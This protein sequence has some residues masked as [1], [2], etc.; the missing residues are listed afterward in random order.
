[1][2]PGS[3]YYSAPRYCSKTQV[4]MFPKAVSKITPLILAKVFL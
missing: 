1:M 3:A 2:K 4:G